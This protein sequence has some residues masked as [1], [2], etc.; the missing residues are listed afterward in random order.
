MYNPLGPDKVRIFPSSSK[1][2]SLGKRLIK[3]YFS[4]KTTI[5]LEVP[6]AM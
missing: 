2:N 5:L 3:L 1:V 6:S 4:S